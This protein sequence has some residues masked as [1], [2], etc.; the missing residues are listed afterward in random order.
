MNGSNIS[1]SPDLAKAASRS[2]IQN[3]LYI[4]LAL[5]VMSN[6]LE[7]RIGGQKLERSS[8]QIDVNHL[9]SLYKA[10]VW[11][12]ESSGGKTN[13]FHEKVSFMVAMR[14]LVSGIF[15]NIC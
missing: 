3:R 2:P 11:F 13:K 14:S 7:H 4:L 9:I 6:E 15:Y 12:R 10:E 8:C 5:L 1:E